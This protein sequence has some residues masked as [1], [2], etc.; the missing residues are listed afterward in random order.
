MT[1]KRGWF[2]GESSATRDD[3]CILSS[4]HRGAHQRADGTEFYLASLDL[5]LAQDAIKS[6]MELTKPC[7]KKR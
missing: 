7:R 6:A 1:I 5:W 3:R 2:C 4:D